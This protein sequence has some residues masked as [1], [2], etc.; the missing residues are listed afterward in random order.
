MIVDGAYKMGARIPDPEGLYVNFQ[1]FETDVNNYHRTYALMGNENAP[2][3]LNSRI[4]IFDL[5]DRC[6]YFVNSLESSDRR[7]I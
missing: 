2:D 6:V 5:Y 4:Y 1:W 7:I 3:E